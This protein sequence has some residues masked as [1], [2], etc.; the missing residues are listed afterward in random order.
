M[1]TRSTA[2]KNPFMVRPGASRRQ[3]ARTLQAAYA[4]GLLSED[5]FVQRLDRVLQDRLIDPLRLIGD[6]SLRTSAGGLRSRLTAAMNTLIGRFGDP[7]G[8]SHSDWTLLALDWQGEREELLLGRL[9]TC[10]LSLSDLSVSRRHARLVFRDGRW[11]LQDLDST[12]GTTVNGL[13]VGRCELRPGDRV[14]LGD[15]RLLID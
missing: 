11:I 12:N 4:D 3:I 5:T 13:R 1:D 9:H 10:D 7:D 2:R 6:L 14:M 15:H 8:R